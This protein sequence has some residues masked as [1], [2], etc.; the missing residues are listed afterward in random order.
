M[1]SVIRLL[2]NWGLDN[3]H[4]YGNFLRIY[5]INICK[6]INSNTSA[7]VKNNQTKRFISLWFPLYC[8]CLKR[9][10]KSFWTVSRENQDVLIHNVVI[11]HHAFLNGQYPTR[12]DSESEYHTGYRKVRFC[13]QESY[14]GLLSPGRSYSTC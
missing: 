3:L 10:E 8:A 5:V 11:A 6:K 1:D 13:Q 2:S 7:A 12:F 9:G 4:L 14:S